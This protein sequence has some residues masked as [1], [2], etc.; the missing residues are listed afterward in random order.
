VSEPEDDQNTPLED[1]IREEVERET[2]R[3]VG[4]RFGRLL[5]RWM[6]P[7]EYKFDTREVVTAV[8]ESS[9][10]AKSEMVRLIGKE[11]R[12][13]L[14]DMGVSD[15]IRRLAHENSLEVHLSLRLKPVARDSDD[16]AS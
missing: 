3:A 14:D 11:I 4:R 1:A 10:Q 13:T 15:E 6:D 9:N 16:D 5:K 2:A 8:L 7:R 12:S